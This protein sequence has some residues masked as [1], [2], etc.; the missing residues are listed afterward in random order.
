MAFFGMFVMN[1]I[2]TL[3]VITVLLVLSVVFLIISIVM[4]RRYKKK[5]SEA[6]STDK[7]PRKWYLVPKVL[8]YLNF[9]PFVYLILEFAVSFVIAV[10]EGNN[11]FAENVNSGNYA[12][13]ETM[14]KKGIDPNCTLEN[15]K[16]AKNGEETLLTSM[17]IHRGFVDNYGN[18]VDYELTAE[19]IEMIELLIEYGADVNAVSYDH[20]ENYIS[21]SQKDQYRL[22]QNDDR[23]GYTPLMYAVRYGDAEMVKF[24]IKHGADVNARDFCGFT[25]VSIVADSLNDNTGVEIL[26]ILIENGADINTETNFGQSPQWLAYRRTTSE[27]PPDNDEIIEILGEYDIS[28]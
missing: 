8:F 17:C 5:L 14:L 3:I 1:F 20:E 13:V 18:A 25:P 23:C 15:N 11:S 9:V 26:H 19:E 21:H 27:Y 24:L 12:Q 16:P 10:I 6:E 2:I 22:Y 7:K 4:K 28:N